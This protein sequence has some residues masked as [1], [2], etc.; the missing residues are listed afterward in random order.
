[1]SY[2]PTGYAGREKL[3]PGGDEISGATL[4]VSHNRR[5]PRLIVYGVTGFADASPEWETA[6]R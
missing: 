6:S 2:A 4:Y 1:M 5:P 3:T